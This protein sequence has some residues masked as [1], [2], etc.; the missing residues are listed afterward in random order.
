MKVDE[1]LTMGGADMYINQATQVDTQVVQPRVIQADEPEQGLE[2]EKAKNRQKGQKKIEV[3][4][5]NQRS[6]DNIAD[7]YME[8]EQLAKKVN[9]MVFA[10]KNQ[11]DRTLSQKYTYFA[12][13]VEKET[14]GED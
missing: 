4:L 12:K 8:D 5:Y 9:T 1:V 7:P 6:V 14:E 3:D 2:Y 10:L 11:P 13:K